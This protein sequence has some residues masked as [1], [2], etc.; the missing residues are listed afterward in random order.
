MSWFLLVNL[1][2]LTFILITLLVEKNSHSAILIGME[3][4]ILKISGY[5]FLTFIQN[6]AND[7]VYSECT[8]HQKHLMIYSVELV[9]FKWFLMKEINYRFNTFG[10]QLAN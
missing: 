10:L 4:K 2:N 5:S 6:E 8:V 1:P 9:K 3:I 7:A